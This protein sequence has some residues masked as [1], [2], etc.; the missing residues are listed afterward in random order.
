MKRNILITKNFREQAKEI[1]NFIQN[2]SP[3]NAN[4]F[5]DKLINEIK[6]IENNPEANPP[7]TNFPNKSLRYRY[8]LFMKSFKIVYKVLKESLIFIGILHKSQGNAAYNN[9]RKRIKSL[10]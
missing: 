7:V 2:D 10:D 6:T 3:Q 1:F 5:I 4:R 8:K 9:L